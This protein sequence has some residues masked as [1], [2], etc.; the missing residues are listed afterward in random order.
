MVYYIQLIHC[1]S[2]MSKRHFIRSD[3]ASINIEQQQC[4]PREPLTTHK[5]CAEHI[6]K[7]I[8]YLPAHSLGPL[9]APHLEIYP[10]TPNIASSSIT[11]AAS[12]SRQ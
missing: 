12:D 8:A 2:L 11:T 3:L 9:I 1:K 10:K 5:V 6:P 7:T 4:N